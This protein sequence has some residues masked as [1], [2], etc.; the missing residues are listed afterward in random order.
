MQS[1]QEEGCEIDSNVEVEFLGHDCPESGDGVAGSNGD[2]ELVFGK[3][4]SGP[5]VG[6]VLLLL[7]GHVEFIF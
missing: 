1:T 4:R 2:E 6:L 5:L 3:G 7:F